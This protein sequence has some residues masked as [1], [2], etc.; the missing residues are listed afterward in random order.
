M[1]VLSLSFPTSTAWALTIILVSPEVC[2]SFPPP[3]SPGW[4]DA[5]QNLSLAQLTTFTLWF[6][7]VLTLSPV[8]PAA[9][10]AGQG[11][12]EAAELH[13]FLQ[14][15]LHRPSP[16]NA[17]DAAQPEPTRMWAG[18][19]PHGAAG[20]RPDL[21]LVPVSSPAASGLQAHLHLLQGLAGNLTS[22]SWSFRGPSS[23][24]I[25]VSLCAS[26]DSPRAH[27]SP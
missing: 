22:L 27:S 12:Q 16:L 23:P 6:P 7:A 17:P 26:L 15:E 25:P 4:G 2:C 9:T 5:P 20:L 14:T 21:P 8:S 18:R 3:W 19:S 10:R 11:R 13:R 1:R 24:K